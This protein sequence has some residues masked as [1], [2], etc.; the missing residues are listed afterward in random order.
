MA[1]QVT[2][3]SDYLPADAVELLGSLGVHHPALASVVVLL[4]FGTAVAILRR[5]FAR[6]GGD[7]FAIALVSVLVTLFC[8]ACIYLLATRPGYRVFHPGF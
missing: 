2:L 6:G 4:S 5:R 7:I 1:T 8:A 3:H